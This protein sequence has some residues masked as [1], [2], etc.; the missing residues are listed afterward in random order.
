MDI[1]KLNTGRLILTKKLRSAL[2][3]SQIVTISFL[4]I[5]LIG[6]VLLKLPVS[7]SASAGTVSF[8]DCLFTATSAVCV[9]GLVT[10]TT[11]TSWS[12]FGKII[13]LLLIQIGG[14][15]IVAIITY[16]GIH[17]GKRITL[18]ERLTLQTAFNHTDFHGMVRMVMFVIRG[19]LIFE[20][21]GAVFLFIGFLMEGHDVFTSLFY[22]IFHSVSAF[23]NAGFDVIGDKSLIPY[24]TNFLICIPIM[25]L[26]IIGGI[27]FSVWVDLIYNIKN[28]F[29]LKIKKRWKFSLHTK[30]VLITTGL[31]LFTGFLY[32]LTAEYNNTRLWGNDG[33]GERMF[34]AFFQSVTL[35][36][37][38]FAT[39]DQGALGETSKFISSL[40]M[41]IGG[42]PGGTAGGIK[43]VTL[44]VVICSVWS[45]IK[46]R[47][48]IDVFHKNIPLQL[49][50]KSLT[51]IIIMTVLLCTGTAILT[52]TEYNNAYSHGTVDLFY[53][54][55]S[56]LGTVG[57]TT[58][59]TPFLSSQGKLLLILCMFIGRIGPISILISLSK[60]GEKANNTIRYPKEDI[61]IG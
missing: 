56:A 49:L 24:G 45:V 3:P 40:F 37:A 12:L 34:K 25:L 13:I 54:V 4:M 53:E 35:R 42:S 26:I 60:R 50:Q 2:T 1:N 31:L 20:G 21:I 15:G 47:Y 11:A 23:C 51:I 10:V 46:G 14:L 16:L 9:T 48:T 27:G 52:L 39:I 6:S 41:I 7:Q 30:L 43:T 19:T 55:A 22:G 33:F 29:S 57:L 17:L 38:G 18:K 36:T 58:G 28:Y 61:L 32:F 59:I 8:L 44:A 5:I